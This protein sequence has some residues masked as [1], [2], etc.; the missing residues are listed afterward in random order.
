MAV[1]D[2]QGDGDRVFWVDLR[3]WTIRLAALL[4]GLAG[5]FG[6]SETEDTVGYFCG[7]GVALAAAAFLF[8]DIKRYFDGAPDWRLGDFLVDDFEAL[9]IAVALLVVLAIG[10]L[11]LAAEEPGVGY[12]AGL[13]LTLGCVIAIFLDIRACFDAAERDRNGS[14]A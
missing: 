4:V 13:G 7:L 2:L 12:Y 6:A 9:P 14:A 1:S 10:G 11:F 8:L 5:L 3:R